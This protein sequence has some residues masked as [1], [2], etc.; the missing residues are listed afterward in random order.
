[1]IDVPM[2]CC[3]VVDMFLFLLCHAFILGIVSEW[4]FSN[5]YWSLWRLVSR[6]IQ[7]TVNEL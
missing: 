2:T 3:G 4:V 7:C 6:K 1:M 5:A